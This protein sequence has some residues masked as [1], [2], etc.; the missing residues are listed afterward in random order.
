MPA[1]NERSNAAA[2]DEARQITATRLFDAPRELVFDMWTDPHIAR[3]WG[4]NGFTNTI[5]TMDVRPGGVWKFV[6]HGPDGTDYANKSVYV[7]V[8]RPSRLVYDHVS[9]PLFR[10]TATFEDLGE[11]TRVSV[12]MEFE[13]AE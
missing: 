4:P 12:V 10:A 3:W 8:D 1:I 2:T 9:G 5:E 7:E 11:R 13:S 6:M